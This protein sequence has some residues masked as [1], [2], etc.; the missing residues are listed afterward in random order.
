MF[1]D[2]EILKFGKF[3]RKTFWVR[4]FLAVTHDRTLGQFSTKYS[5]SISPPEKYIPDSRTSQ[6]LLKS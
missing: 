2:L 3:K 6:R 4:G 5:I 1:A